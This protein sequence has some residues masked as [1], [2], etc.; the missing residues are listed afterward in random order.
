M[1]FDLTAIPTN[2]DITKA[3][4]S[5]YR[6][7]DYL[8][9]DMSGTYEVYLITESWSSSSATWENLSTSIGQ[10]TVA[11]K[12]YTK[13]TTGWMDFD[14]TDATGDL[15]ADPS[16]NYGFMILIEFDLNSY[17]NGH[18]SKIHSSESS[19]ED[20]QPKMVI[21]YT[22]T[23][24]VTDNVKMS[25]NQ[26]A[27]QYNQSGN[28]QVSTKTD[29]KYTILFHAGNGRQIGH[30]NNKYLQAGT[31]IVS[32]SNLNLPKGLVFITLKNVNQS[33]NSKAV[34]Y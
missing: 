10:N 13:G 30:I 7:G 16:T 3:E 17:T 24:I 23:P 20:L 29:G 32:C 33:V 1:N 2:A 27:I 12:N 6:I 34:I 8:G 5:F 15:V 11:T 19:Q 18:I 21:E 31:N 25:N 26:M 9:Y 4:L 22:A 28:L 14:V